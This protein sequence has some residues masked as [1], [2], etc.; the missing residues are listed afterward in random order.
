MRDIETYRN[1]LLDVSGVNM[2][3]FQISKLSCSTGGSVVEFSP[4]TREARVRFPASAGAVFIFLFVNFYFR[5]FFCN[6]FCKQ[7]AAKVANKK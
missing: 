4:A 3:T 1:L 2:T 6:C 5:T 7:L